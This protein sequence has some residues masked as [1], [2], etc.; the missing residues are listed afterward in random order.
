M[1]GTERG[2]KMQTVIYGDVFFLVNFSMD[3]LALVLT[4]KLSHAKVTLKRLILGEIGR[5]HV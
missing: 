2:G 3:F 1:A 4:Q 5:A